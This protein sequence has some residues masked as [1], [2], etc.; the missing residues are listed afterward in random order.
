MPGPAPPLLIPWTFLIWLAPPF[1]Y[2]SLC[3]FCHVYCP[4]LGLWYQKGK[5][6]PWKDLWEVLW[7][8]SQALMDSGPVSVV[9]FLLSFLPL[10]SSFKHTH[11][12]GDMWLQLKTKICNFW[13]VLVCTNI[14]ADN[15]K[16]LKGTCYLGPKQYG[17]NQLDPKVPLC[18][19]LLC[20]VCT[21]YIK[22]GIFRSLLLDFLV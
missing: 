5:T 18:I 2:C 15:Y 19:F 22:L 20:L 6:E 11:R 8:C 1:A 14:W 9:G 3:S 7:D 21:N 17:A 16:T 4:E 13:I 10:L 12:G